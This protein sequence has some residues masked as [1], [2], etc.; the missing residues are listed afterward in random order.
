MVPN[1]RIR[2]LPNSQ[3][4]K[5]LLKLNVC[6]RS[7]VSGLM[8]E[9]NTLVIPSV[10]FFTLMASLSSRLIL[11][12]LNIMVWLNGRVGLSWEW[13]IVCFT[14][15]APSFP[16]GET[17]LF[18]QHLFINHK[19]TLVVS[20]MI[21]YECFHGKKPFVSH[22]KIF[23]SSAW[24]HSPCGRHAIPSIHY[25]PCQTMVGYGESFH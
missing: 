21:P 23:G 18:V 10:S 24:V 15:R 20:S 9:E 12:L 17:Q 3:S 6:R 25:A 11:L 13:P 8:G 4:S 16:F 2:C 22:F 14:L 19:P 5:T 1:P 7:S